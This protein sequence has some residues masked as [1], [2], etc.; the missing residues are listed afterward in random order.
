VAIP[1]LGHAW[2]RVIAESG[3]SV[4][5]FPKQIPIAQIKDDYSL[6]SVLLN[7]INQ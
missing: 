1:R 6:N 4:D 5:H 2:T 3:G 7:I